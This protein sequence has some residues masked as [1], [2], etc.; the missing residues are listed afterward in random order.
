MRTCGDVQ[1][2]RMQTWVMKLTWTTRNK[3][4][5]HEVGQVADYYI[6][7]NSNF[8]CKFLPFT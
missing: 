2:E 6:I 5:M 7:I 4:A 3:G 8:A 1:L